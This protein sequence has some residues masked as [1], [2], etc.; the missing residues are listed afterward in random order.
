MLGNT[1]IALLAPSDE[2]PTS[3][4][5]RHLALYAAILD[6]DGA[7]LQWADAVS[8]LMGIDPEAHG[9][10]DCW[11]SHLDRARWIV[12]DGLAQAVSTF[13]RSE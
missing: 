11:R 5:R 3:Y 2:M 12:G 6:A 9:A 8:A 1:S 7:R 4:D 10:E 13:G